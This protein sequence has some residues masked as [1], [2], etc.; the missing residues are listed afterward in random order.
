MASWICNEAIRI[1]GF[2]FSFGLTEKETDEI[3]ASHA[4]NG[5]TSASNED[6]DNATLDDSY[7]GQVTPDGFTLEN[8]ENPTNGG[9]RGNGNGNGKVKLVE[10]NAKLKGGKAAPSLV[11]DDQRQLHSL[12]NVSEWY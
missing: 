4:Q 5:D 8:F 3:R 6:L 12:L 11:D 10:G 1:G 2:Q 7:H 9:G